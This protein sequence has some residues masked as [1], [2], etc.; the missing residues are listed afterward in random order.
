[1]RCYQNGFLIVVCVA[2]M[3]I[4][5]ILLLLEKNSSVFHEKFNLPFCLCLDIGKH[6]MGERGKLVSSDGFLA[7]TNE[8][9]I[10]RKE[11]N[12]QPQEVVPKLTVSEKLRSTV[13]SVA[14]EPENSL[15]NIQATL[16]NRELWATF[17]QYGN[18]MILTRGGR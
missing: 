5:K 6:L 8:E 14:P 12:K 9:N 1:M 17:H 11:Q 3:L 13:T 16:C 4:L 18:E 10:Q 7:A 2:K 15:E